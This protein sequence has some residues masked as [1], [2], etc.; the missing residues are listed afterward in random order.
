M[1]DIRI[2]DNGEVKLLAAR[3]RAMANGGLQRELAT[4]LDK[5]TKH[6]DLDVRESALEHLPKR[7]GLAEV[8]ASSH[9]EVAKITPLRV[10]IIARGISQLALL[11]KGFVNHPTYGHR[12]WRFEAIAKARGWFD[13]PLQKSAPAV[14]RE[15]ERAM[16]RTARRI[17]GK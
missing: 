15:L 14:R 4:G 6:L 5:A 2:S 11:N 7:G 16:N 1:T 17:V 8:V 9:I 10:R 12:P 3:L 13:R